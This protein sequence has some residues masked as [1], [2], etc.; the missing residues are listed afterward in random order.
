M[1]LHT[2]FEDADVLVIDKP[3]GLVVHAGNMKGTGKTLVDLIRDKVADP[4]EQRPGIV[5]RLDKDT[6][7]VLV[8]AKNPS[9]KAFLQAQFKQRL[10]KKEYLAAVVGRP[11]LSRARLDWPIARH[12]K[13]PLKRMVRPNGKPAI[14]EYEVLESRNGMSLLCVRPL[15]G[16]THQI[17]VHLSHLGHPVIGDWLYGRTDSRLARHFLHALSLQ[18]QLT[19]GANQPFRSPLPADLSAFWYN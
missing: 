4:D 1:T 2:I 7:G 10:V 11:R 8:I 13:N 16:R 17:R 14:T 3:A 9:A 5:H 15:T 19:D 12:V 18:L 6:S